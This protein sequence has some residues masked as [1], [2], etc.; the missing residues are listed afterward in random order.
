MFIDEATFKIQ[1]GAGGDGAVS[2]RRERFVPNGGPDGGDGGR[3]G[4]VVFVG[5]H[6]AHT[7][8]DFRAKKLFA[9]K[10]GQNGMSKKMHGKNGADYIISVPLGTRIQARDDTGMVINESDIIADEQRFMAAK[11]GN[12]GWGNVHF[13]TSTKQAPAWSKR[14]Q[15]GDEYQI[16]LELRLIADVGLV[17]LPN[18]GKS[19]L[20]ASVTNARPKIANYPFTTLEP[21]LGVVSYGTSHCVMADIPGLIEGASDNKGLGLAFL[22]HIA[23]T[24]LIVYI[25]DATDREPGA[26]LS[27]LQREL[28]QYDPTLIKKPCMIVFNKIDLLN[29][30]QQSELRQQFPDAMLVSGATGAGVSEWVQTMFHMLTY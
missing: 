14:G 4:S 6:D 20:L 25:I 2:F 17:G 10:N 23:R 8:S 24:K 1:A 30:Q 16:Y 5:K 27:T 12:G 28:T 22:K 7:L 11:G 21:G 26:D 15:P 29:T 18:A 13:A 3:G 9:A 19:T